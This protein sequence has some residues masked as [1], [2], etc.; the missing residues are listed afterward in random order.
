MTFIRTAL[1]LITSVI[2]TSCSS[3]EPTTD[4]ETEDSS[5]V[6]AADI[7]S[8]ALMT[9]L[10]EAYLKDKSHYSILVVDETNVP[11]AMLNGS[12]QL[13]IM[14]RRW[15]DDEVGKFT[16]TYGRK[17]VAA[18]VTA[19]A[20][21]IYVNEVN[22]IDA[23]SVEDFIAIYG[24][25]RPCGID[26]ISHWSQLNPNDEYDNDTIA[27]INFSSDK[28][29][30]SYLQE[31][32]FCRGSFSD[33]LTTVDDFDAMRSGIESNDNTLGYGR[34]NAQSDSLK[35]LKINTEL[36]KV[37]LTRS[38]A[39]SGRYPLSQ[40]YYIYLNLADSNHSAADMRN[41]IAFVNFIVSEA[42]Q[43]IVHNEGFVTLPQSII[44]ETRVTLG[45]QPATVT[46]GYR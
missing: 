4:T 16:A 34:I 27:A 46:G 31:H 10:T 5:I 28:R 13:G 6:F 23:I 36:G 14:D 2:I 21:A 39:L 20:M 41:Q 33:Q 8:I 17:P 18:I 37:K 35:R 30:Y 1:L 40:V 22:P 29:I 45:L 3:V 15:N 25:D 19:Y 38:Y 32:V 11:A 24:K 43:D 12:A 9:K 44:D 7:G 42:G 26:A